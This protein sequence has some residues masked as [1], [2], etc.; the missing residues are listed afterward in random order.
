MIKIKDIILKHF[1]LDISSI[2]DVKT[3]SLEGIDLHL[4]P[5][6]E[7]Q[8]FNTRDG[9]P[10]TN[11][12]KGIDISLDTK[13]AL[14]LASLLLESTSS[15]LYNIRKKTRESDLH[16]SLLSFDKS[17]RYDIRVSRFFYREEGQGK[18][19]ISIAV[20]DQETNIE[21]VNLNFT[22]RDVL[23]LLHLIKKI[24]VGY[25]KERATGVFTEIINKE[26]EKISE[27]FLAFAR[28]D[29]SIALGGI[30]LHGQEIMS[31]IYATE[32]LALENGIEENLP[33]LYTKY[34]QLSIT[35]DNDIAYLV[36]SKLDP[37]TMENLGT[38]HG[39]DT[40]YK[41]PISAN[42]LASLFL[43]TEISILEY[44]KFL[45]EYDPR[46]NPFESQYIKGFI[47]LKES[48]IGIS[49]KENRKQIKN[50]KL[51]I[52]SKPENYTKS[53]DVTDG[54][55]KVYDE[56]QNP[57]EVPILT[58]ININLFNR[59]P[60]LV[61]GLSQAYTGEYLKH[62]E[63]NS[64]QFYTTDKEKTTLYKY[65]FKILADPDNKS[66]AVLIIDKVLFDSGKI[67]GRYRQPLFKRY[68]H[69]LLL[70]I[71]SSY[72]QLE[73]TVF[74]EERET[75]ELLKYVYSSLNR[76]IERKR[77]RPIK[78]GVIKDYEGTFIGDIED[79]EN[80]IKL[81]YGDIVMLNI[82]SY[83]RILFGRWIPFTG[84]KISID[85]FG[86]FTDLN[87]ELDLEARENGSAWGLKFYAG[88]L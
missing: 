8:V 73:E 15:Y 79:R 48:I 2:E 35:S 14:K 83:N 31:L 10:V 20:V 43:N 58:E 80:M 37:S 18:Y 68:L 62:R 34:R 51:R 9:K 74:F 40:K 16:H 75:K 72:S 26:D 19:K 78:Y 13:G 50:M 49:V 22:K 36:L 63:K 46:N 71:I 45:D 84:E 17:Q 24:F 21:F 66:T 38:E 44:A 30:W 3:G 70:L 42:F 12:E 64:L 54:Y 67:V 1:K 65:E 52:I 41:I 87:G 6:N 56:E 81:P 85:Q 69:Q 86:F 57:Y 88:T 55:I 11:L 23:I 39:P 27:T 28:I 53:E 82:S 33:S 61:K 7:D 77:S 29:N 60:L 47:S 76:V 5:L 32:K 25:R 59:W 4:H